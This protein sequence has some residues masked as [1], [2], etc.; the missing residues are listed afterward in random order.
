MARAI[1]APEGIVMARSSQEILRSHV[2]AVTDGD[3]P[4]ILKDYSDDAVLLT[5]QG[6]P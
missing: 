3:I 2:T 6:A 1:D 4:A 5:P